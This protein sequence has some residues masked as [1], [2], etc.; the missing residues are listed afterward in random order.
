MVKKQSGWWRSLWHTDCVRC[1]QI[2]MALLWGV[3][4]YLLVVFWW[5]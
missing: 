5:M 3:L 1:R 4:M 2:R